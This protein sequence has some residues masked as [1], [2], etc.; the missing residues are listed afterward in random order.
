M[1]RSINDQIKS[2]K[3]TD[4]DM[5]KSVP[6]SAK[7]T[8]EP[9]FQHAPGSGRKDYVLPG[10]KEFR[11][12]D[13]IPKPV[14]GGGGPA[15]GP[16]RLAKPR[17]TSA[18]FCRARKFDL[19]EDL[20][21]PDLVKLSLKEVSS[22]KPRRAGDSIS[23]APTNIN[24]GQTMRRSYGRRIALRRPEQDELDAIARE[25][26]AIE[27][28]VNPEYDSRRQRL[29]QLRQDFD[30]LERRRRVIPYVDPV[31][32]RFN[33]FEPQPLPNANAVMFCLMDVSGSM[34]ERE[35]DLAK[36]FFVL[37][38]LFLK[39]RYERTDIVFVRHTH[40]AHEVDE[41]TFFT[42]RKA[43]VPSSRP[44]LKKCAA[45]YSKRYPSHEWNI[46]AAQASDGDNSGNDRIVA[47]FFLIGR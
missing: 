11:A 1:K 14:L 15:R 35:K 23:G 44:L 33:R 34:G 40:E 5:E 9:G 18:S 36:R 38:H 13:R 8:S 12:G 42:A 43:G 4:V 45:S 22:F 17:T 6:I 26:S 41:E 16:H 47:F 3:I 29:E 21:L 37:L 24:V 25:V 46:Y 20:E 28:D 2:G 7:G 32:I 10:N 27:A 19:F 31:D 30:R 39:R